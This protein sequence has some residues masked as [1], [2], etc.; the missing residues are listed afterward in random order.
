MLSV[1]KCKTILNQNRTEKLSI[2]Q[3]EEVKSLLEFYARL[4]V[5]QFKNRKL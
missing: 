3:V 5:E 2:Q 4:S 1:K